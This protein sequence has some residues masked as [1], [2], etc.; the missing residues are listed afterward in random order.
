MKVLAK[1]RLWE[2]SER[3]PS[4]NYTKDYPADSDARITMKMSAVKDAVFGPYTP[5]GELSMTV[6]KSVGDSFEL[7]K[8]YYLTFEPVPEPIPSAPA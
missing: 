3:A 4:A 2:K 8:D 7:G 1:F 5:A 6:I